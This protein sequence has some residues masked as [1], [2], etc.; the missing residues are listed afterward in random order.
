M[1]FKN[2]LLILS[3]RQFPRYIVVGIVNTIFGYSVFAFLLFVGLHYSIAAFVSVAVGALFNFNTTGHFVF[4]TRHYSRLLKFC[5]VYLVI[6]LLK[7]AGLYGFGT[8]GVNP[9]VGGAFLLLPLAG[10]SFVLNKWWVFR[11]NIVL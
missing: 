9:Y 3:Q 1:A 10:V 5:T 6:Y 7:V 2:Q 8:L 11:K 4:G